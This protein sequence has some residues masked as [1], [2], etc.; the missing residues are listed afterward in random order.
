MY[1]CKG[2]P[3]DSTTYKM[4]WSLRRFHLEARAATTVSIALHVTAGPSNLLVA[5]LTAFG[6]TARSMPRFQ[7]LVAV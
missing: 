3:L 5:C 2:Y 4:L 6:C 7:G 1:K